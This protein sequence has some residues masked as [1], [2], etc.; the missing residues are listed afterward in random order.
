MAWHHIN[1]IGNQVT[2]STAERSAE[3][4][5]TKVDLM[6]PYADRRDLVVSEGVLGRGS[7]VGRTV[8]ER[9]GS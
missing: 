8:T 4:T 3:L 6:C 5:A 7:V 1:A 9:A 2:F